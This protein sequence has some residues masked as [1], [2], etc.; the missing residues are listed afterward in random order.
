V[1]YK[2]LDFNYRDNTDAARWSFRLNG[3]QKVIRLSAPFGAENSAPVTDLFVQT[4]VA[5]RSR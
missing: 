5:R 1:P 2:T 3:C 4:C